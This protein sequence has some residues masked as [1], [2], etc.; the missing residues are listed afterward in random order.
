METLVLI[1]I[2]LVVMVAGGIAIGK[3]LRNNRRVELE[4]KVLEMLDEYR[5]RLT[6][7]NRFLISEKLLCEAFSEYDHED[8][9]VVWKRLVER[10][11]VDRDPLDGEMC[12][13]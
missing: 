10:R 11:L 7:S 8:I 1:V 5:G 9:H 13:R 12:I 2:G 6:G 3:L 4:E